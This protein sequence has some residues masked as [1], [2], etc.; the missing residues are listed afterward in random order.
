[1]DHFDL[2]DSAQHDPCQPDHHYRRSED[3]EPLSARWGGLADRS[4]HEQFVRLRRQ[5]LQPDI[6]AG[7]M[8]VY[9][10]G[11]GLLGPGLPGWAEARRCLAGQQ[12]YR[13]AELALVPSPLLPPAERRRTTDTVK[14][15]MAVGSEAIAHAAV[16]AERT[17]SVFTSSGGDGQTI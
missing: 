1:G 9:L 17:P 12:P 14:L 3:P 15:A 2:G 7:A 13:A 16:S 6:R 11:I 10:D 4:D 5:Q 8:K